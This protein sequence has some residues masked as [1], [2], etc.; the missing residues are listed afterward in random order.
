MENEMDRGFV[1]GLNFL[2]LVRRSERIGKY[3]KDYHIWEIYKDCYKDP[4]LHFSLNQRR[5]K[6]VS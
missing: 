2:L 1:R 3:E 4:F 6:F 5:G